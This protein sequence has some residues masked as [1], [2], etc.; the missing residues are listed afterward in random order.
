MATAEQ[1]RALVGS[2]MARMTAHGH[3]VAADLRAERITAA[4]AHAR[5]QRL[6]EALAKEVL[7]LI[8]PETEDC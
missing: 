1:M 5:M 7:G 3:E 2:H 8:Y 6:A 4:E